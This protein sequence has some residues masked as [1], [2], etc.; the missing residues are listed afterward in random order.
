MNSINTN[1]SSLTAQKNMV[2]LNRELDQA[3]TRLSSGLR[4][5]S[6]ADDAAGSAIASKMESQVRSLGVAIR[7]SYD[8]IS[9]TQT[10]EGALGEVENML[11]RVREL[12]V[13]AGNST[14]SDSDRSMIQ[15]EVTALT[16][17][18]D[19]IASTTHFNGVNLLD[20]SKSEVNF[21]IGINEKDSLAVALARTDT[22]ALGL[23][24]SL[25]VKSLS[26]ERITEKNFGLGGN[27][28]AAADIKI[29]GQN[30]FA[31]DFSSDLTG[32]TTNEAKTL[33]DAINAN[34]G[35][36]NAQADA[37]NSVSSVQKGD[38]NMSATFTINSDTV[39][40][41]TS[42]STLVANINQGV[43]GVNATL[44]ADNTITLNN[45]T[46]EAIVI[47]GSSSADVGFTAGT[48]T[49]MV[50]LKNIDGSAVKIEA[51]SEKNGYNNGLGTIADLSSI[52]FNE[53]SN[54]TS[55]ETDTVSGTALT[56]AEM[57]IN[58]VLLGQSGNG[59][60]SSIASAINE[61]TSE[62]GVTAVAKNEVTMALN[63]S[64]IPSANNEFYINKS[65]INLKDLTDINGIVGAIN[66]ANVGD[67][68]A[69]ADTNGNL[70]LSSA[71]GSDI[72]VIHDGDTD[73]IRGYKDIHGTVSQ[74]GIK[75]GSATSATSLRAAAAF[76]TPGAVTLL[77]PSNFNSQVSISVAG[78]RQDAS[79]FAAATYTAAT[80]F[81]LIASGTAVSGTGLQAELVF[82]GTTD[83]SAGIFTVTGLDINGNAQTE[84]IT[85][86]DASAGAATSF[87]TK[88]YSQI[89]SVSVD[90]GITSSTVKIS[91]IQGE[92]DN[93]FT[94]VGTDVFGNTITEKLAGAAGKLV[95]RT[96][97]V[98]QSV[99][100]VNATLATASNLSI[101]N[102]SDQ[103]SDTTDT[104]FA[105][106]D[107][108][109]KTG[110]TATS[111]LGSRAS[112]LGGAFITITEDDSKNGADGTF[113][114][115]GTDLA[116]NAVTEAL[117]G[118][119]SGA[120]V[121]SV[122]AFATVTAIT[123]TATTSEKVQFGTVEVGDSFT[124]RGNMT[125]SN[126]TGEA[127][128]LEAVAVDNQLLMEVKDDGSFATTE[129]TLQKLGIQNQ[130]QSFEVKGTRLSVDT[131]VDAQASLDVIDQAINQVSSFRSSFGAV[132][133]RIDASISN[134]TTLKVN[135]QAA[136]SR[137][138]DADFAAET[139]HLT[140]AQILSQAATTM[141]AQANASKQN[142]LALLQG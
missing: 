81:T 26:S 11:Q 14:L 51:G 142:L 90:R 82:G 134:L 98:F 65:N 50:S 68:K 117:V 58:D 57:K 41:A 85:G 6:A 12:A 30:A 95:A 5:N 32:S 34:S 125:L 119:A 42:Y 35:S 97:N 20:G 89:T 60:A 10:A 130:S 108:N 112:A 47:A 77:S 92:A 22:V 94:V 102:I 71:S 27:I 24:G 127:I 126:A 120:T 86:A 18:I 84:T 107:Y 96:K 139:S 131:L 66:N 62:H 56:A 1:M 106:A 44:N 39:A 63:M 8:A 138:E 87:G 140:K 29:N 114:I 141:L 80:D 101:G 48:Y 9:M 109:S 52:G 74:S 31:S 17:E 79:L 23:A 3:M 43:S 128:K 15:Q 25:G 118:P 103:A 123:N 137:I 99:T 4:I 121:T 72:A 69:S 46:G 67:V 53:T 40:L 135:T 100:S 115:V 113:T 105:S 33:A 75:G 73:F 76:A 49:G 116:G 2:E 38:F 83:A 132:E 7:N 110:T 129:T 88:T 19:K 70:V 45:T 28:I 93:V 91:S 13:Q 136:Q 37:F 61:K 64:A 16:R 124:A 55:V 122:N 59:Q 21:Q 104:A 36:H 78:D 133:N 111:T 54:G